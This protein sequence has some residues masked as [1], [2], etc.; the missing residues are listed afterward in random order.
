[1]NGSGRQELRAILLESRDLGFLGPGPVEI[2]IDHARGF[3]EA[4]EST[5]GDAPAAFVDL[6]TGGGVPGLV[7]AT[8]WPE[9]RGVFVES[10]IRRAAML[11]EALERLGLTGRIEVLQERA[12]AVAQHPDRRERSDLATARSFAGPAV[13]A[14]IGAGLVRV[15]GVVVVS[16]PPEPQSGRWPVDP[17]RRLGFGPAALTAGPRGHFVVLRKERPAPSDTPRGVGRPTKRPL[18]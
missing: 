16:E 14:E 18:W 1:M 3:V 12:E 13:T 9:A 4:A 6:G 15:G 11:R 2:H 5:L 10:G 17:L 7:L 8:A